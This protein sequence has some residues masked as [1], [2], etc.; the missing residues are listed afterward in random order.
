MITKFK[1]FEFY[2]SN[3]RL[4]EVGEYVILNPEQYGYGINNKIGE[5]VH[6]QYTTG[7]IIYYYILYNDSS[8]Y[9]EINGKPYSIMFDLS[10][11][12]NVNPMKDYILAWSSDKDKLEMIVTSNN[13]NL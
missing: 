10:R 1:I 11:D 2:D 9:S 8:Q 6:M 7:H 5:I 3:E 4:P 12:Q 13:Y